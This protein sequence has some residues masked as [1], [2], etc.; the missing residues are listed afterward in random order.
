VVV[1][2]QPAQGLVHR[3]VKE[4]EQELVVAAPQQV[5]VPQQEQEP[6]VEELRRLSDS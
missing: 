2:H 3:L 6:A 5:L 1:A 4:Q